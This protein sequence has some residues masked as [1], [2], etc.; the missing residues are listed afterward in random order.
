MEKVGKSAQPGDL[1][2][3]NQSMSPADVL[4]HVNQPLEPGILATAK[5]AMDASRSAQ[6]PREAQTLMAKAINLNFDDFDV[7]A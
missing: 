5:E 3:Q 1:T 4:K 6:N 2:V 7:F